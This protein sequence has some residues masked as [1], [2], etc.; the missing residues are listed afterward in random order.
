MT[1]EEW[2]A[3]WATWREQN[4][5]E[6]RLQPETKPVAHATPY[7]ISVTIRRLEPS[8]TDPD[9]YIS[10]AQVTELRRWFELVPH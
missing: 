10:G 9:R 3:Y 7:S 1:G 8:G 2:K 6:E 4:R 5:E